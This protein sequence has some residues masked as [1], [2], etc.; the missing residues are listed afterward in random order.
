MKTKIN[1]LSKAVALAMGV[2]S[3]QGEAT[4]H[5]E[6]KVGVSGHFSIEKCKVD[7][8]GNLLEETRC[9]VA[10][11][12]KNLILNQ[13]LNGIFGTSITYTQYCRVG[14]GSATPAFTDT[15]LQS[16]IANNNV[17][18]ATANGTQNSTPPY[19][20]WIRKTYRFEAGVATGNISEV[21]IGAGTTTNLFSRA[22]ILD[23]LGAPTTITVL[24]DEVL[25]VIYELRSYAPTVDAAGTLTLGVEG[26]SYDYTIRAVNVDGSG[27][28]P[29][30]QSGGN[31]WGSM[32]LPPAN[33]YTALS[34]VQIA[35]TASMTLGGTSRDGMNIAGSWLA[36]TAGNYY[37]DLNFLIDLN[38]GN[39][40]GGFGSVRLLF[41]NSAWS[42]CF[43]P[44]IPKNNTKK[45][46]MVIRFSVARV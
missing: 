29:W 23:G 22:L 1:K 7:A 14:S 10:P 33:Y 36:Y 40:S 32:A 26:G 4:P 6:V 3:A 13:G 20:G 39:H 8:E 37:R 11:W 44:I 43:D 30:N 15:A 42:V 46:T 12:Q 28:T 27:N 5:A 19:Y 17:I 38:Y 34:N 41:T 21:G 9:V 31:N 2:T 45:F 18:Q 35:Q 16:Q 25:D 24:S